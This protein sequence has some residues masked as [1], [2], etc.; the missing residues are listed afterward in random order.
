MVLGH[1]SVLAFFPLRVQFNALDRT[2]DLALR[3][4][5]MPHALSA[6]VRVDDIKLLSHRDGLVGTLWLTNITV[7]ALIGDTKCHDQSSRSMHG[8]L[9]RAPLCSSVVL[10]FALKPALNRWK[11]KFTH[12]AT[13]LGDFPHNCSGYELVLVRGRHEHRFNIR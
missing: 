7:D 3:L 2:N 5:V 9:I 8:C 11:H 10:G 13:E 4:V 1:E 6:L 12:I